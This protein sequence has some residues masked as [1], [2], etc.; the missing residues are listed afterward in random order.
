MLLAALL[1]DIFLLIAELAEELLE[2][3]KLTD[4]SK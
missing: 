3:P 1:E 2:E 4:G